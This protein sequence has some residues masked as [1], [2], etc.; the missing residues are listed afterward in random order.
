VV[1]KR[2]EQSDDE[3][4]MLEIG[5]DGVRLLLHEHL[6]RELGLRVKCVDNGGHCSNWGEC[7]LF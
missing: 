2:W 6:I 7:Y 4:E 1:E 3:S 5:L